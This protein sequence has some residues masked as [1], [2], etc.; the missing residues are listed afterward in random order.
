MNYTG[1]TISDL[2]L[3]NANE[4]DAE[5]ARESAQW[6]EVFPIF[7]ANHKKIKALKSLFELAN[8]PENWD[9]YGSPP[10][11]KQAMYAGRIV[12]GY[13]RDEDPMPWVSP[14]SGGGIQLA[15]K[16]QAN[17]LNL[18]ILPD[19]KMECLKSSGSDL[20]E[21]DEN[22]SLDWMRVQTILDWVR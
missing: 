10:P 2:D 8:L 11:T 19:G 9:S 12:V 17:E 1:A 4:E 22:F 15:W 21:D 3:I 16:K 20:I 5:K 7:N 13:L 6:S 14:V 18:D